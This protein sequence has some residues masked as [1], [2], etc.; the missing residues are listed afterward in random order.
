MNERAYPLEANPLLPRLD[1]VGAGASFLCAL[2]C[3]A[4]PV[5]LSTLP[6]AGLEILASH[7]LEQAFVIAA[8]VF[9]FFVIGSGYCRH[10]LAVVALSY[11]AGVAALVTGAFFTHD[12]WPHAGLLATG[13]VM[14]GLAHALN[15]RGVRMHG[16]ARNAFRELAAPA[17]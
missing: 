8:A 15:R 2:H 17:R 4:M 13:G 9:G 1:V 5:L 16:C 3:A 7:R 10:R 11:L 14:L 6:L 12:A